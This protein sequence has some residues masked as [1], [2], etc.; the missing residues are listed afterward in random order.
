LVVFCKVVEADASFGSSL[1]RI[2][3]DKARE[4]IADTLLPG[5]VINKTS[6]ALVIPTKSLSR[7]CGKGSDWCN[8][9][10]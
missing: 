9:W 10:K 6:L 3:Y 7:R 2:N 5:V 1:K 4:A 8:K